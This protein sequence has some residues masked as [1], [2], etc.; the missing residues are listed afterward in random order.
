MYLADEMI[1]SS[2]LV[3]GLQP[4][5]VPSPLF[6]IEIRASI[7]CNAGYSNLSNISRTV[8][9]TW[10]LERCELREIPVGFS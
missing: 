6:D 4:P 2:T 5:D 7:H 1:H 3:A 8:T 10:Y 9:L